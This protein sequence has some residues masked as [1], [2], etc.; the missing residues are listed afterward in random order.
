MKLTA[1]QLSRKALEMRLRAEGNIVRLRFL[2]E[3]MPAY[4][5]EFDRRRD[6]GEP[7][8]LVAPSA[9][10]FITEALKGIK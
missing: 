6:A 8:E 9:E 5:A 1:E 10:E 4:L 3:V 7:L 2:N